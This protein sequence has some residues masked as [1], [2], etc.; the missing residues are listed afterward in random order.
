MLTYVVPCAMMASHIRNEG[1]DMDVKIVA[2]DE[3][4]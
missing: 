2:E 4:S 1:V 3:I